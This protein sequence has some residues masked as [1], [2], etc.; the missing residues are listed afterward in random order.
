[1]KLQSDE[2]YKPYEEN[3]EKIL[4]EKSKKEFI[5]LYKLIYKKIQSEKNKRNN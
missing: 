3:E 2:Q 5:R 4:T 1:M